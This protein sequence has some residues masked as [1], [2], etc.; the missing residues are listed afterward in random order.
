MPKVGDFQWKVLPL[1]LAPFVFT[2]V[3]FTVVAS[4]RCRGIR[5]LSIPPTHLPQWHLSAMRLSAQKYGLTIWRPRTRLSCDVTHRVM[6]GIRGARIPAMTNV[7][8]GGTFVPSI[9]IKI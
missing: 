6:C 7:Y 3:M 1:S 8:G 2:R 5:L 4:L 9:K